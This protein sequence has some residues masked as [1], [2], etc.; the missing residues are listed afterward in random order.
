MIQARQSGKLVTYSWSRQTYCANPASIVRVRPIDD[1]T[2]AVGQSVNFNIGTYFSSSVTTNW[3]VDAK[4]LPPGISIFFRQEGGGSPNPTWVLVGTP[5]TAGVYSVTASASAN[6][7]SGST[8]FKFTVTN[9]SSSLTLLAPTYDCA[10]GAITFR[11]SGG[12]GSPIEF[13]A[14]GITDWTTN[15]NQF[16]DKE[17]RTVNDVKP[18]TLVARQNGVMVTYVWDLKAACGRGVSARL[19]AGERLSEL[20]ISVLGKPRRGQVGGGRDPGRR[21]PAGT[22]QPDRPPGT[23]T[24]PAAHRPG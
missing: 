4:G 19:G 8:T 14:I 17:S 9:A 22:P 11:S 1:I 21:R 24:P 3:N 12:N 10:T 18:F 6:G 2:V 7:G 16:V 13:M 20:S 5:T 23:H 15:P